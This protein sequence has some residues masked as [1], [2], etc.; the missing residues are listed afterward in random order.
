MPGD[1]P[2]CAHCGV[3][4]D[5][6]G[7]SPDFCDQDCARWWMGKRAA[8]PAYTPGRTGQ[9]LS[10]PGMAR[11]LAALCGWSDWTVTAERIEDGAITTGY[12]TQLD[13]DVEAT[14]IPPGD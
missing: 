7:A 1:E 2:R 11:T 9:L 14:F 6:D 5:P 10:A 4:I 13:L 12:I 3:P 8:P